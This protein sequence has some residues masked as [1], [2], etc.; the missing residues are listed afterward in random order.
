VW[1]TGE[2]K[3]KSKNVASINDLGTL[4]HLKKLL[5]HNNGETIREGTFERM[6]D[7]ETLSL[8]LT[9]MESLPGDMVHMSKLRRLRLA[10]PQ[11]VK[12][13]STSLH[14]QNLSHL[15]LF[16]CFRLEELPD[17]HKLKS[18]RQLDIFRC[19]KL[20]NFSKEFCQPGA[21]VLLEVF[22]LAELDE[23][24]ELPI[25]EE[26]AMSSLKLFTI[27]KCEALK[28]LPESYVN[29]SRLQKLRV[30]GCSMIL[31]NL[32]KNKRENKNVEV[33]TLSTIETEEASKTFIEMFYTMQGWFYGKFR[34]N[35]LFLFLEEM[36][37]PL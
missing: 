8:T 10:C 29:L 1:T 4:I 25:V 27:M 5:L 36:Y 12:M 11:V 35:E 19:P 33:V 21:F 22:S 24:E 31:E 16:G 18:L 17:L 3:K 37:R 14:F 15:K 30:F 9:M 26:G 2:Q 6:G 32:E 13:V 28:T 34:N 20:K 7:M 23:L